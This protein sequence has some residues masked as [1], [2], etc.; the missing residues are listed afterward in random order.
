M[1][2]HDAV[3]I[4][5]CDGVMLWCCHGVGVMLRWC[6]GVLMWWGDDVVLWW[7]DDV[8]AWCCNDMVVMVWWCDAVMVWYCAVIV[9]VCPSIDCCDSWHAHTSTHKKAKTISLVRSIILSISSN[10]SN[11]KSD[12]HV[13]CSQFCLGEQTS[14]HIQYP[15][16]IP[17]PCSCLLLMK[18]RY[19]EIIW[20]GDEENSTGHGHASCVWHFT[21]HGKS[22]RTRIMHTTCSPSHHSHLDKHEVVNGTKKTLLVHRKGATRAF[23]PGHPQ[24]PRDYQPIGLFIAFF[25]AM[26]LLFM[27][28]DH[29]C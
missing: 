3:M 26:V 2:C 16:T 7:C 27:V 24:I 23:G 14:H 12:S 21:Q 4:W 10:D 18:F 6:D 1:W 9:M 25:I 15:T 5:W 11:H 13:M 17:A 19:Q 20:G 29:H 28:L 8:M 22:G